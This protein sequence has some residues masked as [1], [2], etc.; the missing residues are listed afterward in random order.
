MPCGIGTCSCN[1]GTGRH[2]GKVEK[3]KEEEEEEEKAK[4]RKKG[5]N[6]SPKGTRNKEEERKRR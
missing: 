3:K 5:S 6:L 4:E 1:Q 2:E